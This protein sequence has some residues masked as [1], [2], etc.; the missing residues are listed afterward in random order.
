MAVE[1]EDPV[2]PGDRHQA[3]EAAHVVG[4][5]Y[6]KGVRQQHPFH[7]QPLQRVHQPL[8]VAEA[9]ANAVGPVLQVD[10]DAYALL[11]RMVH[12]L[13][14]SPDVLPGL[15]AQLLAAMPLRSLGQEIDDPPA[16]IA[17]PVHGVPRV[18]ESEH[19][20]LVDEARAAGPVRDAPG[21]CKLA[22]RGAGGHDLDAVHAHVAEKHARHVELFRRRIGDSGR[23]LAVP[24][25]RIHDG[26]GFF[27]VAAHGQ[28]TIPLYTGPRAPPTVSS[29]GD[30][31]DP[32]SRILPAAG[33]YG[34]LRFDFV[35]HDGSGCVLDGRKFQ[36]FRV[37][38][39]PQRV[40]VP[41]HDLEH[42][43]DGAGQHVT[44]LNTRTAARPAPEV[45]QTA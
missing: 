16:R 29:I 15:H 24:E 22:A 12:G 35:E 3:D 41:G 20:H 7:V 28:P 25:R 33:H 31:G 42:E 27:A 44:R 23:L 39:F 1:V 19:L 37:Q 9:V 17:D 45:G 8:D 43:I 26:Y 18:A 32:A 36:Q 40:P 30:I 6:A 5:E 10:I 11:P 38:E 13:D 14:D 34:S 21:P 2:R 4:R